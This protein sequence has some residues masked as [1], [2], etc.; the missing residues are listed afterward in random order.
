[1]VKVSV[2]MPVYKTNEL[3]L[4]QA[5]ES[6]LV[7]DFNDFEFLIAD[8]CPDESVKDIVL[9]YQDK[10][11]KYFDFGVHLGLSG[12]RNKLV[13]LAEGQYL[14]IMDHDD[15]SL[16]KRFSEEVAYLDAHPEVGV[17]GT[18]YKRFPKGRNSHFPI[19]DEEI[20]RY[21][22]QGCA[23]LHPSSMV[24][25]DI[26]PKDPYDS[27]YTPAEDYNMWCHLINKTQF[28]NIPKVLHLYRWH[29][30][31]TTRIYQD[32]RAQA[33]QK[34]NQYMKENHPDLVK[35][36]TRQG[37]YIVR[38]KLFGL[39]PLGK[40]IQQGNQVNKLFDYLPFISVKTKFKEM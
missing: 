16:P 7:Q 4:R 31:N 15:I 28:H 8:D 3:Y 36:V 18:Q 32:K 33:I 30:N 14:A 25:A 38:M 13:S 9:S 40:F 11:I 23:I 34:I 19:S 29:S 1:M 27:S 17:V 5:I 10:R 12:I 35:Q 21:L 2:L 39:I 24:R 26:L 20:K 6:I 37:K 22:V